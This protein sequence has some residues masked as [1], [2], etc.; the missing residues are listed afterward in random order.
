MGREREVCKDGDMD[1]LLGLIALISMGYGV[2]FLF[3]VRKRK[4]EEEQAEIDRRYR[5]ERSRDDPGYTLR[6]AVWSN[7][8]GA[9]RERE[10]AELAR[11]RKE[12]REANVETAVKVAYYATFPIWFAKDWRDARRAEKYDLHRR[13]DHEDFGM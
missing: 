9:E 5:I 3:E 2:R 12:R 1:T 4:E 13:G 7:Q 11:L 10:Q 8:V 6:A